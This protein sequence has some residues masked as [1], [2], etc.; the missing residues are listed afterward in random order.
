MAAN[1]LKRRYNKPGNVYVGVVSRIDSLVSGVLVLAKTS[2]AASRLSEQIRQ[3]STGKDYLA[4]TRGN[5]SCGSNW[6][7]LTHYLFK[8]EMAQQMQVCSPNHPNS[9]DAK[10]RVRSLGRWPEIE[11]LQV[12]LITGRKH[13]IRAQLAAVGCPVLGDVKYG[14]DSLWRRAIGLHCFRIQV[15]HPTLKE[16]MTFQSLP[17]HW[18]NR[19]KG[20]QAAEMKA[21]LNRLECELSSGGNGRQDDD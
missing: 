7:T 6:I 5:Y 10:L 4:I 16:K 15:S 2:K 12:Q 8:N 13:Q 1:Y 17:S 9:Q 14:G 18:L 19:L 11:L 21:A 20:V 3:Q